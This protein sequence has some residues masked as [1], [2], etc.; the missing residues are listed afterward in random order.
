ME[1]STIASV[2]VERT[3]SKPGEPKPLDQFVLNFIGT[4]NT[5]KQI[6]F[7]D[8]DLESAI[9]NARNFCSRHYGMKFKHVNKL[10]LTNIKDTTTDGT[11]GY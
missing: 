8:V 3:K 7:E 4:R 10:H 9:G 6:Y 5:M 1:T 2:N 11:A